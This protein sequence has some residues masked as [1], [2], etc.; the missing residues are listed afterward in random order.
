LPV[1]VNTGTAADTEK[2]AVELNGVVQ[3]TVGAAVVDP[4]MVNPALVT[5]ASENQAI[6][7]P[8]VTATLL[9]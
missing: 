5:L 4:Q 8:A 9:I 1:H 2:N 3:V 7:V 6:E